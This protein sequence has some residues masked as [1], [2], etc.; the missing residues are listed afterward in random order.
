MRANE[1]LVPPTDVV[2]RQMSSQKTSGT[3]IEVEVRR[4][5]HAMGFR[6]RVDQKLLSDH[7]F[8]GDLSWRGRRL[9]VFLDGCFWHGC[10][11]HGNLP[12]RNSDWWRR[13][14]DAN[15]ERDR[16]VDSL[17]AER[18]WTVLRF[19]EHESADEIVGAIVPYLRREGSS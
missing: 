14:F 16:K 10:P 18:G 15:R 19:W 4:R 1:P 9:V 11:S 12:K 8:R 17:L 3:S 6:F 5:L 13:K 2:R 7:R